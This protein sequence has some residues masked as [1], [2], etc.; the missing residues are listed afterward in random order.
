MNKN[1]VYRVVAVIM[2]GVAIVMATKAIGWMVFYLK[3]AHEPIV[4]DAKELGK[5]FMVAT[6]GLTYFILRDAI[7]YWRLA[8]NSGD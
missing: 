1:M 2:F 4:V 5:G 8:N 7:N 6:A 3:A